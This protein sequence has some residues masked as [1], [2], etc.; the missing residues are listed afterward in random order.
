ME[1]A[2]PKVPAQR[3]AAQWWITEVRADL[4]RQRVGGVQRLREMVLE[5][6]GRISPTVLASVGVEL[7]VTELSKLD[8]RHALGLLTRITD[9]L[10]GSSRDSVTS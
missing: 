10:V 5:H 2:H 3:E 7:R 1:R 8:E 9:V 6:A 4:A